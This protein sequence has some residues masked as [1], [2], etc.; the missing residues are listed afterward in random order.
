[1][2]DLGNHD[3]ILGLQWFEYYDVKPDLRR[4]RLKWPVSI[5]ASPHYA[6]EIRRSLPKL[7]NEELEV[8]AAHH[9]TEVYR[10]DQAFAR[11]D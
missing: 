3:L 7:Y 10:R 6:Q 9:Q 8:A 2:L 1:M 5:P 4:Q 11:E